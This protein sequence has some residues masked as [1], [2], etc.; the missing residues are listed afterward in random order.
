[1]P[2]HTA[3]VTARS[4]AYPSQPALEALHLISFLNVVMCLEGPTSASQPHGTESPDTLVFLTSAASCPHNPT[5]KP[6]SPSPPPGTF[7]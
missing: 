4:K 5:S 7:P 2:R 1:M 3:L 6:V